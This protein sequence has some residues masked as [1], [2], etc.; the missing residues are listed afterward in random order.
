MKNFCRTALF[1][2]LNSE[3]GLLTGR[4]P[5]RVEKGRDIL[6]QGDVCSDVF[7]L[8]GGLVKFHYLTHDG[9]EW[10]KSFVADYGLLGSRMSQSLGEPSP[11]SITCLEDSTVIV[12]PYDVFESACI[13]SPVLSK[14]AFQFFQWLG[15]KK[16]IR[17]HDL[18]CLAAEDRYLKFMRENPSLAKR[19]T[20]VDIARFLGITPVALSRIKNR[21]TV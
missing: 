16:E 5:Q 4:A 12:I 6:R 15:L 1:D 14:L 19:V 10:V 2:T 20:Q 13:R 18:L 9:K 7:L 11:F 17:E 8:T 21:T 3:P